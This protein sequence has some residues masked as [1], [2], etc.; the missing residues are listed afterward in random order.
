M[1]STPHPFRS[2]ARSC[3]GGLEHWTEA[4]GLRGHVRAAARRLAPGVVGAIP[5]LAALSMLQ[6]P[7]DPV[8]AQSADAAPLQVQSTY[9]SGMKF[10]LNGSEPQRAMNAFGIGLSPEFDAVMSRHPDA[11]AEIM[12]GRPWGIVALVGAAGF[13][14]VG[15]IDLADAI[16]DRD[17]VNQGNLDID[18]GGAGVLDYVITGAVMLTGA[19]VSRRHFDNGIRMFNEAEGYRAATGSTAHAGVRLDVPR[20][21]ATGDGHAVAFG[22]RFVP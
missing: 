19:I 1:P 9:F 3:R 10:T 4:L 17:K 5:V 12:R 15:A 2:S 14:V 16:S 22:V 20:L 11:R 7:A 18:G 21:R 8:S 6:L 13:V